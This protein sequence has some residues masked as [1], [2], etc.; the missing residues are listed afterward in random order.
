MNAPPESAAPTPRQQRLLDGLEAIFLE[1][2][3]RGVSVA[4]LA[5]RLRCSRRSLYELAPTK[6]ALFLRVLDRYL[7]RLRE[8]GWRGAR[9]APPERAFEPYL[10]PAIAAA[11][12]LSTTLM[13]DINGYPPASAL[14]AQ[15]TQQRME[16]L[17]ELVERC[18]RLGI[19]RG[20]DPRLVAEVMA[21]SLRR[22]SDPDFL[23]ESGL[24]YREAVSELYA[25][26]L[27]G[28]AHS[29]PP[30]VPAGRG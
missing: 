12:R 30:A 22:I 3:L 21:A 17:R 2:G 11:R 7:S 10:M 5:G 15:H 8:A 27:H 26:L 13:R 6:E 25:L 18:V 9:A 4:E 1:R 16:G 19:F 14:W 24:S 20:I 29:A 28:L 23:A